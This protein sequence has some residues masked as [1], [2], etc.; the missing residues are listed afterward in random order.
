MSLCLM[1]ARSSC[2]LPHLRPVGRRSARPFEPGPGVARLWNVNY[3][4]AATSPAS[5]TASGN[6]HPALDH[7]LEGACPGQPG[8]C[9]KAQQSRT[10][11]R[12]DNRSASNPARFEWPHTSPRARRIDGI[13]N[14]DDTSTRDRAGDRT[15]RPIEAYAVGPPGRIGT[16]AR[17]V[18]VTDA[19]VHLLAYGTGGPL[20][21]T[22]P[23]RWTGGAGSSSRY[24]PCS[25]EPSRTR[26]GAGPPPPESTGPPD[27]RSGSGPPVSMAQRGASLVA[28]QQAGGWRSAGHARPLR[29]PS[30]LVFHVAS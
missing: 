21:D 26:S 28:M 3:S 8:R 29:P 14:M 19:H 9:H 5:A 4:S 7:A 11:A 24:G 20:W 2:R 18:V 1:L 6:G 17:H 12:L 27:T 25:R 16:R 22:A 30:A 15:V 10:G 23:R 13:S